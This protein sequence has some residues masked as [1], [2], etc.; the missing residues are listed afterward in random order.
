MEKQLNSV[1]A[2]YCFPVAVHPV[3]MFSCG[4]ATKHAN[5]INGNG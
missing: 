2:Y 1:V 3:V 5:A 4:L